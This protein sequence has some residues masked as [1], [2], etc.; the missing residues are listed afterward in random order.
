MTDAKN[1]ASARPT[2]A[3]QDA[4]VIVRVKDEAAT[5]ERT[6]SSLRRQT[7]T[8][9][10]IVVD[11]GSTDGSL[12][13]ATPRCDHLIEIPP[14]EFSYGRALNIGARAASAPIH[15]ALSAHSFPERDDWI[16]RSLAHYERDDVAATSSS[17][18]L[19]DRRPLTG[20]F[21]QDAAHGRANPLWGMSNHASSWRASVWHLFPFDEEL[22]YA[23]DR[24]WALR[25]L[26][27]GWTIVF[28]PEISVDG[29]HAWHG[30]ARDAFTRHRRANAAI[31]HFAELPPYGPRELAHEWWIEADDGNR[32]PWFNRFVNY[33]RWAG[34]AGKY[35]G[36]RSGTRPARSR[37]NLE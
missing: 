13:I 18:S 33:R 3:V 17:L 34:L 28:D 5:L 20:P 11:S 14:E 1:P 12:E 2:P 22:D 37:G 32:P 15:F 25:V 16:E 26:D 7:I 10:I 27:A 24:E 31:P 36:R 29:S 8:P 30:G 4:S 21:F 35:V 19:P 6:L 23:E 9:D